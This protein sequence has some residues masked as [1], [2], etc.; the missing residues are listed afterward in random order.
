[1]G[2]KG[3][4]ETIR[5]IVVRLAK[6]NQWG[7]GRIVGELRK[8][9]IRCVGRTTVRTILM[10][11]GIHPAQSVVRGPGTTSSRSTPNRSGNGILSARWRTVE[12]TLGS[13]RSHR[14]LIASSGCQTFVV[15]EYELS[16]NLV[17][18]VG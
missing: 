16:S 5:Q 2:R 10:E 13:H 7:Y 15:L 12:W 18:G 14:L 3:T 4:P 1:M 8:L 17:D 6:Q 9:R 11:E